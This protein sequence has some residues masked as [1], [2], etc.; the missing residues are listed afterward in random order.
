M[1]MYPPPELKMMTVREAAARVGLQERRGRWSCPGCRETRGRGDETRPPLAAMDGG[2]RWIC[3]SC[4]LHGDSADLL[5]LHRFG[6]APSSRE[7]R[8]EVLLMAGLDEGDLRGGGYAPPSAP[9][10]PP[11]PEY[12]PDDLL[13]ELWARLHRLPEDQENSA[14]TRWLELRGIG[15]AVVAGMDLLRSRW[16]GE[17][18][19]IAPP[20]EGEP[21]LLRGLASRY[22]AI[23]PVYDC[24]GEMQSCRYRAVEG[25]LPKSRAPSGYAARGLL[26]ADPAALCWLRGGAPGDGCWRDVCWSGDIVITE[27]ETDYLTWA[28]HHRRFGEEDGAHTWATV[29]ICGSSALPAELIPRIEERLRSGARVVLR[30]HA[31]QAG[32]AMEERLLE[33]LPEDLRPRLLRLEGD[34]EQ[35]DD[36]A[37]LMAGL[38]PVSPWFGCVGGAIAPAAVEAAGGAEIASGGAGAPGGADMA[39]AAMAA[40]GGAEIASGAAIAPAA[41]LRPFDPG[42]LAAPPPPRRWLLEEELPGGVWRGWL[43]RGEIGMLAAP[44]GTGKSWLLLALALAVC[45]GGRWIGGQIATRPLQ[46]NRGRVALL[47]AEETEEELRRR[48][49]SQAQLLPPMDRPLL[50]KDSLV[51]LTRE[52]QP[53]PLITESNTRSPYAARL[54]EELRA[55][56]VA[57]GGL[58]LIILDPLTAF[59]GA[60]SETDNHAA[61]RV[62]QEIERLAALPGAPAVMVVHHTRKGTNNENNPGADSIRGAGGLVARA[63]W[64]AILQ[65]EG[66][67]PDG[68]RLLSLDIVKSNYTGTTGSLS[69]CQPA[70]AGGAMRAAQAGERLEPGGRVRATAPPQADPPAVKTKKRGSSNDFQ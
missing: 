26:M 57:G 53:Q 19:P 6:R 25:D 36:N 69:I 38:L 58:D 22:A 42:W 70:G 51:W 49:W 41:L 23:L 55:A 2:L 35:N 5:A 15:A 17:G 46:P 33:R 66:E 65:R 30:R 62:M 37:R 67:L 12:P 3:N 44:G 7:E 1:L 45:T 27:G 54:E 18:L 40:A 63:R 11:P 61:T 43:P 60:E 50:S 39:P 31:D 9:A 13:L 16:P 47:L 28:T 32:I 8:R 59:G 10:P 29:G 48:I 64:A 4:G 52:S 14:V 56:A 68:S 21:E 24:A 34:P 20:A